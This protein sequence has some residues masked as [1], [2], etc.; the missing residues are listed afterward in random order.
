MTRGEITRRQF[1]HGTAALAG[2]VFIGSDSLA[3]AKRTAVDQ[4]PLGTTGLKLSRLGIGTGSRGGSVQRKLGTEGFTRLIRYAYDK[5]VR[6]IDTAQ[7]YHTHDFIRNA[8]KGL[9]REKF[10]I[11]TKMS[12]VPEKPLDVIDRF[13]KEL[14]TD[15]LDSLLIHCTVRKN[16][17]EQRKRLLEAFEKA[18]DK[19]IIRA[20]GVSCHSLPALTRSV[21]LDWVDVHLVRINPQGA[22]MDTP[23]ERWNARSRKSHVPAVMEQ[24]KLMRAKKHGIIGM[25]IIGEGDFTKPEDREASVRFAMRG[26]LLDAVVIGFKNTAEIDEAILRMNRA[27]TEPASAR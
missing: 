18:K 24:I 5:G 12:G 1:I 23:A 11:Q 22:H 15:Y 16:W 8:I 21:E 3:A 27:L 2:A 26:N 10:F 17:D 6:F 9:P 4:V 19:K 20:H 14:N 13:R 7:S 25:K